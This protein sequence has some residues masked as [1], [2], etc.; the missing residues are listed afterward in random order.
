MF[1]FRDMRQNKG[2]ILKSSVEYIKN[3]QRELGEKNQIVEEKRQL[4]EINRKLLLRVQVSRNV[5]LK[6][7]IYFSKVV[8][9][10][11]LSLIKGSFFPKCL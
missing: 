9:K 1:L 2:T 11:I 3:L 8:F 6:L 7:T 4:E 5:L 10:K